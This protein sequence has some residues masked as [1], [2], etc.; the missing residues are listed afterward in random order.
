MDL[1]APLTLAHPD[2]EIVSNRLICSGTADFNNYFVEVVQQL[3]SDSF[4]ADTAC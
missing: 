4:Q 1:V 3:G 2:A